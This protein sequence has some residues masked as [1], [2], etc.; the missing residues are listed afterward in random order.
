[1]LFIDIETKSGADLR[2]VGVYRYVEDPDFEIL[3]A[4]WSV[5]GGEVLAATGED[6][7]RNIP[8]LFNPS[9]VK[10]AHNAAFE[11][12]CFSHLAGLPSGTYLDPREYHDTQ[13][14][15][16]ERGYPQKLERLAVAL[17]AEPKDPAGAALIRFFCMPKRGGGFNRP[18]DHP[19][20]WAAFVEYCKQDV[21]TLID[22]HNRL[23]DFPTAMER[24]VYLADQRI[25]DRGIRVDLELARNAAEAAEEN[26]MTQELEVMNLTG[27]ANPNSNPQ[28]L[29]WLRSSGLSVPNLRA[30]TVERLLTGSLSYTQ[31]RVLELRQELALVASKKYTT[32]LASA[33]GGDRLRGCFRFFGAHTGRWTG[34][35]VQP[36]NL[37]R[38]TLHTPEFDPAVDDPGEDSAIASEASILD[39]ALG[40]GGEA[41]TLKALVRSLFIINGAVVDYAAIE[42][43][44][45]SWLAGEEWALEAFR[46]GRDIYVET[47]ERMGGLTR[48]QGKVA[49]LA[50]GYNGGV[51]ALRRMGAEGDDAALQYL[52]TQWRRANPAVVEMWKTMEQAFWLGG[53]VGDHLHIERTRPGSRY[54]HL[55]SGRS[56][57]YHEVTRSAVETE[58]GPKMRLQFVDPRRGFRVDTYG[59][60][61]SENVTQA[62][63][64]DLLAEALVR[65][66][67]AGLAVVGHV[68]DEV[69]VEGGSVDEVTKWMT[70]QPEWAEGLPLDGEGF[71]CNRYRKG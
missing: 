4:A 33:S 49:V 59:G 36:Q 69:L 20:K 38:A 41:E 56:I 43:R 53:K 46:V 19:E 16:G 21:S 57:A 18:Q 65:L 47:A 64:R 15:A 10:I 31:R 9:V 45:L 14:V 51:A 29:A 23:G 12:V 48:F 62:V 42:A 26:Q 61:L 55:P 35:G 2:E 28:M 37:P 52:V 7:V 8:G 58:Y 5:D 71:T 63:A 13:A 22:V 25:N 50:L 27:I 6:N 67:D 1:M 17:G 68:H 66:D 60:K 40:L 54:I 30:E 32:A 24:A 44:V 3:M 11:R 70:Q 39:L 34:S